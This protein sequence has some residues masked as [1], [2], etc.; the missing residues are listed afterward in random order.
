LCINIGRELKLE[1]R[2]DDYWEAEDLG[3]KVSCT[4]YL[5]E[6][7][8]V[9]DHRPL[10]L[11][12][13]DVDLLFS[14]PQVYEDFFGLLRSWHE[15]A[16]TRDIWAKLRLVIVHSTDVYIRLQMHQSPFN[17]GQPISLPDFSSDQVMQMA[18]LYQIKLKSTELQL[19]IDLI[20][21]H[22][23]L[24]KKLFNHVRNYPTIS[25]EQLLA[26]ATTESSLFIS[27]LREQLLTLQTLPALAQA[28][29]AAI[30][31]DHSITLPPLLVYQLQ[32]MGLIKLSENQVEPRCQL[33]KRYFK[34]RLTLE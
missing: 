13:D 30:A 10:V 27:H 18:R 19:I 5:E 26:E 7:L 4:A 6:H 16:R 29:Q 3:A 21:G 31:S 9:Q 23:T 20:G 15:K 11:C 12:F 2:L 24:L 1:N 33:Y 28:F 17:V 22:P 32:S 34:E 25:V 14:H 8:L